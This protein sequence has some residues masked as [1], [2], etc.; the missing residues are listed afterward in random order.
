MSAAAADSLSDTLATAAVLLG[1]L[2]GYFWDIRIDGWCGVVVAGFILWAGVNA[3]KDTIDPLLGQPPTPEFVREVQKLVL[4]HPEI[5]GIHDLI[6]HDYGPGRRIISLHAEVPA[7]GNI[8]VLHDVVD[9][10][11]RELNAAMGC[12]ATIHMDPVE[13]DDGV[14]AE[15]RQRVASLVGIIDPGIS[16][17]DFR[18]VPGHT[19]TNVIFDAVL[20]FDCPLSEREAERRIQTAVRALDG[21]YFAVVTVERGY[22]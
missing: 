11:E 10:A 19:H 17:H 8:L 18:M 7:N 1:T 3:A 9:S 22:V 14:T 5:I 6:V 20:P 15:T 21:N 12:L 2:A 4:A 13:Q 16:I